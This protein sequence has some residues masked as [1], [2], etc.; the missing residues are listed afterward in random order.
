MLYLFRDGRSVLDMVG[1]IRP[2][3]QIPK[4]RGLSRGEDVW[5]S[6]GACLNGRGQ[7]LSLSEWFVSDVWAR[8]HR[9]PR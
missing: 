2:G 3:I 4:G 5:G 8:A 6:E 9:P 1:E 7:H